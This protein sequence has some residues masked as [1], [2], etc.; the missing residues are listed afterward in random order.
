M[1]FG[2]PRFD[3]LDEPDFLERFN[4][5]GCANILDSSNTCMDMVSLVNIPFISASVHETVSCSTIKSH[6]MHAL[7]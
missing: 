3:N 7:L 4:M 6:H 1:F 5:S 2:S